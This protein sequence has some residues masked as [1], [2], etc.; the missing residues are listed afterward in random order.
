[1]PIYFSE[2]FN[3]DPTV[4]EGFGAFDVSLVTDLPLFVDPFLL[5]NSSKQEYRDLHDEIIGYVRFLRD[6]AAQGLL[7]PELVSAWCTFPE[8]RQNW[9]G[10]TREGNRGHGLGVNFG[11]AL[12][13]NLTSVFRNFGDETISRGSHLEKLTLMKSGV[14]RDNIS[15]FTT[16]LIKKYL[17]DYTQSFARSHLTLAQRQ[18]V[19]IRKVRFNYA[20]ESWEHGTFE[21]P[22]FGDDYVLLT[23]KDMLTKDENWINHRSLV[24][25]FRTIVDALPNGELRG[26]LNNHFA[27]QLSSVDRPTNEDIA[28]A[29]DE[30]VQRHPEV[31]D[32]FILDREDRG[33]EAQSV[34]SERV[35]RAREIFVTG[36]RR[37]AADILGP[38]GFYDIGPDS[39]EDALA[40]VK[41]LK[42]A[43]E[44][45]DGWR[46][47]YVK[48]KPVERE[49]DLQLIFRLVW[50]GSEMDVNPEVNAGRGAVDFKISKG[51]R[52]KTLVEFK[53]AS[54]KGLSR[55][56]QNQVR[57]YEQ[58]HSHP[59]ATKPSI[60]V[61]LY[62]TQAQLES[63]E[64]ILQTLGLSSDPNVVLID[65]RSDN[66][67]SASVA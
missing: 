24:S 11:S 52:D 18:E 56:L 43:I 19:A 31:L 10:Y 41:F 2:A 44:D 6:K 4:V 38:R 42:H 13:R 26:Q 3:L 29:V 30:V 1:M 57:I 14:G 45:L 53:L 64:R 34:S 15:D 7:T 37:L 17:L 65:A 46:F 61:I 12:S 62:F 39:Y 48:G 49:G 27:M 28:R 25:R 51:S 35:Q 63:V 67:P 32:Y 36:L 21:L 66:K 20:T 16:N 60:K 22:R 58:A 23:P 47:F 9:F 40:R 8:V 33:N 5:F 50:F 59:V 55:N 54:N